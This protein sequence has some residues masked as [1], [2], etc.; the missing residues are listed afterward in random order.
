MKFLALIFLVLNLT[1]VGAQSD[2]IYNINNLNS[3]QS[4]IKKNI[5][6]FIRL[7]IKDND[8]INTW[9]YTLNNKGKIV[10]V[11][12]NNRK[13]LGFLYVKDSNKIKGVQEWRAVPYY[14]DS[15]E[16]KYH[17]FNYAT[18]GKLLSIIN[19]DVITNFD[20]N[21]NNIKSVNKLYKK[22][23]H[24]NYKNLYFYDDLNRLNKIDIS[25]DNAPDTVIYYNYNNKNLVSEI[26]KV[27]TVFPNQSD[28]FIITNEYDDKNRIIARTYKQTYKYLELDLK[29][30]KSIS[31]TY[32][33]KQLIEK[34]LTFTNDSTLTIKYINKKRKKVE[35]WYSN[36]EIIYS[37]TKKYKKRLLK[38]EEVFNK[39]KI[40]HFIYLYTKKF[41]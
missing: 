31:Y 30:Y 36:N 19:P 22:N 40:T 2:S 25:V 39:G 34:K 14:V 5:K 41:Q 32:K 24:N 33:K 15:F 11:V 12:K 20:Y 8:T 9:I 13:H 17:V 4:L 37:Y 7:E 3:S 38:N 10:D 16:M 26:V 21:K 1:V 35:T 18:S 6:E 28:T 23:H 29:N 27:V